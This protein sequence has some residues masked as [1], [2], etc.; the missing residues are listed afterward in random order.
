MSLSQPHDLDF[1]CIVHLDQVG[2]FFVDELFRRKFGHPAP[3]HGHHVVCFYRTA[4]WRFLPLG[5]ANFSPNEDVIL[6]GGAM[7]DGRVYD[8]MQSTQAAAIQDAG[9]VFYLILR[10]ALEA[11]SETFDAFFAYVGDERS[12]KVNFRAGF[13]PTDHDH[14]IVKFLRPLDSS[15]KAELIDRITALGPF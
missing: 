4:D 6:L 12:R 2:P 9:G 10:Y 13:G 8:Q 11:F 5:Y 3:A 7:T 15:R 1:I 14:L